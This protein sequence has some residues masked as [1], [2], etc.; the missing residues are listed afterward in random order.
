MPI[1]STRPYLTRVPELVTES[2]PRLR[3]IRAELEVE[4]RPRG[5]VERTYVNNLAHDIGEV[6]KSRRYEAAI[7]NGACPQAV[8]NLLV[9]LLPHADE[10]GFEIREDARTLARKFFSDDSVKAE[11]LRLLAHLKLDATAIEAEAM[12]IRAVTLEGLDRK[13]A[14]AEQSRDRILRALANYRKEFARQAGNSSGLIVQGARSS[15]QREF[16]RPTKVAAND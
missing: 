4:F 14:F 6:D 1:D 16:A 13:R 8:E 5:P 11:V 10:W 12:R 2:E 7:I 15:R 9:G 3:R